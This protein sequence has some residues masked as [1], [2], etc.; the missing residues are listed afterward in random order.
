MPMGL[1]SLVA[2]WRSVRVHH[3]LQDESGAAHRVDVDLVLR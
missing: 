3:M 2:V 1:L